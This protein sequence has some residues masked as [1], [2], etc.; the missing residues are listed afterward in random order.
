M[1]WILTLVLRQRQIKLNCCSRVIFRQTKV[2]LFICAI[3]IFPTNLT[4]SRFYCSEEEQGPSC[5]T[6]SS[7]RS[8]DI[9]FRSKSDWSK[10][11]GWTFSNSIG[12]IKR[13]ELSIYLFSKF[14]KG[15]SSKTMVLKTTVHDLLS[16]SNF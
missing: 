12:G 10:I 9:H 4:E 16:N 5:T 8:N 2:I 13:I 7:S 15:S 11:C 3:S 1:F 14:K 6:G